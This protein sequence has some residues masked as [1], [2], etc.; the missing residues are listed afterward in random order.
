[1]NTVSKRTVLVTALL[2]TFLFTTH[3]PALADNTIS[4]T[5]E[6][7]IKVVPDEV[8]IALGI[9]TWDKDLN[10]AKRQ[11]DDV[12]GKLKT[13]AQESGIKPEYVQTDYINIE[14]RY[15]DSYEKR[16]FIGYFVRKT[17]VLTLKDINKFD[18]VLSGAL[19]AGANYVHGIEFRTTELRKYRDQAR[20]LAIKAAS[21]KA[22]ALAGE[23]GMEVSRP[24]SISENGLG[25]F[26]SYG[27]YWGG[28]YGG[29]QTQNIVQNAGGGSASGSTDDSTI[30]L[31][32]ITVSASVSVTFEL[33]AKS[34]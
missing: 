26:S 23:I 6:A 17:M 9:E 16:N 3:S 21:E 27:S 30:A 15:Q 32:Q 25:W 11:N 2:I 33:K 1:M 12:V 7:A 10:T 20:A 13:L 28:R 22:N 34:Q 31:G 5:G 8:V 18:D 29:A 4:V 24:I 19:L 14:P